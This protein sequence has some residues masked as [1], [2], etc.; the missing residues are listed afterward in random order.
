MKTQSHF[1]Y[2]SIT[3]LAAVTGS[4]CGNLF[5]QGG[6]TG[7]QPGCI[8]YEVPGE[9]VVWA[10]TSD[11]DEGG[12]VILA[13]SL[14]GAIVETA[15]VQAG[16][17]ICNE[18]GELDAEGTVA[19]DGDQF[20]LSVVVG[21]QD[22]DGVLEAGG[23]SVELTGT[24]AECGNA[25]GLFPGVGTD[26]FPASGEGTATMDGVEYSI[27]ELDLTFVRLPEPTQCEDPF[28][29]LAGLS[30]NLTNHDPYLGANDDASFIL[31]TGG[32][33]QSVD[34]FS[35]TGSLT[36]DDPDSFFDCFGAVIASEVAFDGQQ[37]ALMVQTDEPAEDCTL[38]LD[39][40]V[41][42]C[43]L[44]PFGF[45]DSTQIYRLAGPATVQQGERV[46][47]IPEVFL[48][49]SFLG[50]GVDGGNGGGSLL[51]AP[52]KRIAAGG[53]PRK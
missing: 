29:S 53:R 22:G 46:A 26:I 30:W 2:V 23:C 16:S 48:T 12:D 11:P 51:P 14:S 39:G 40:Q 9:D 36:P 47:Q 15:S 31:N 42:S 20:Q 24:I 21:D 38:T 52:E 37:F 28:D 50:D 27:G 34:F 17:V 3:L 43:E 49:L 41:L 7:N 18:L 10:I 45:A 25:V 6:S 1:V 19:F 4:G 35:V 33:E 44:A 8:A 32:F 5:G 13:I